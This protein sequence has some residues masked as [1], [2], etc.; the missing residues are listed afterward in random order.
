MNYKGQAELIIIVALLAIIGI[1]VATQLGSFIPS[2]ETPDVRNVRESTEALIR[3]AVLDTMDTMSESGGYLSASDYQIGS[4]SL[5]G[6]DVPYWQYRGQVSYPDA[7]A[8]LQSGVQSYLEANKDSFQEALS[9]VTLGDPMVGTPVLYSDKVTLSVTMPTT[10]K[11]TPLAQPYTVTVD[12]H[13][14]EI[15]EFS[16]SLAV[17]DANNRPFEYYTLSSMVMSPMENGHHSIPVY[18][19]LVGCGD[20]MFESSFDV[21]PRVESAIAKTLAFTY[22]P[23][24]APTGYL[25]TSTAPKYSLAPIN[26][27][28][29]E[30]LDVSFML[31]DD[32]GLDSTNFMM[33]PDPATGVSE[34]IPMV[35]SCIGREPVAVSYDINYPAIVTVDDPETGNIFQFALDVYILDNAPGEWSASMAEE[36]VVCSNP[37]CILEI[38]VEDSS[39][40]PVEGASVNFLGCHVGTT[41]SEGEL[42][43]LAPCGSGSFWIYKRGY[44][45]HLESRSSGELNGTVTLYRNP[46]L[47]LIFHEVAVQDQ[48]SGSYMI[49]YGDID[50]EAS[51]ESKTYVTFRTRD[52]FRNYDYYSDGSAVEAQA[53]PVGDYYV[54]GS[55]VS[56]DFQT[57]YGA[58]GDYFTLEEGMQTLHIYIPTAYT[59][60]S[61]T[62]DN[63]LKNKVVDLTEVLKQCG[64]GTVREDAFVQEEACSVTL[65]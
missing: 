54:G 45:Q 35:G 11:E 55:K 46:Q 59:L 15:Y 56:S 6:N 31:P 13:F 39:G 44:G 51:G 57:N 38:D 53:M 30:G 22:M 60:R 61:I 5:N 62:D 24:K 33:D 4:V 7:V 9:G 37:T 1:V 34:P 17:Y 32:F 50:P 19:V 20:Y 27:K 43:S 48:G 23:G 26:N 21:A 47:S 29:Y 16:K 63:E 49:Y 36:D 28:R 64:I 41:D 52:G 58:F 3:A 12:S 10:Y 40:S 18:E 8:N 2:T 65:T 14:G 25:T 42:L